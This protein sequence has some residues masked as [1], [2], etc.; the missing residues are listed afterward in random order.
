[1]ASIL[2][3]G[4]NSKAGGGASILNTLISILSV[5]PGGHVYYF[6]TPDYE[7]FRDFDGGG[8]KIIQLPK[9]MS[10]TILSP[11]IYATVI[12][13]VAKKYKV[14][15]ILNLGDQVVLSDLKQVF[16]FD[17]SYAVYP[18]HSIWKDM[19]FVS[20]L[21]R[22]VKLALFKKFISLPDIVLAQTKTNQD[23]L[24]ALYG[25]S[26]V[27][28]MPNAISLENLEARGKCKDYFLPEGK[29]L[30][31][32]SYYYPHKN[33]EIFLPLARMIKDRGLDYKIVITIDSSQHEKAA[34]FLDAI[35]KE[36]LHEILINVG[37]VPSD[38]VPALYRQCDAL[39]MPTLLESFSGTYVE[40]M[41]HRI[42][43]F[44]SRLP[45]AKDVCED[46]AFY[47]D[48]SDPANILDVLVNAFEDPELVNHKIKLGNEVLSRFPSWQDNVKYLGNVFDEI[49]E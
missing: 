25:L 43:I 5:N 24:V 44:T 41:H 42:P 38:D 16:L 22:R 9:F 30:L 17:W 47:F 39:L 48:P 13:R 49:V 28:L 19:D 34:V 4:L 29:K 35:E 33:F 6:L 18:D 27:R 36:R 3:N 15:M 1:M 46:S 37:P 26:N 45:F 8:V 12:P 2:V 11:I 20:Y 40:A 32:L 14:D 31:Y 23:L 21:N 7:R 10:S